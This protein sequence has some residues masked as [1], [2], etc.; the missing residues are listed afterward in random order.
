MDNFLADWL[1]QR[2]TTVTRSAED[3]ELVSV[4]TSMED[5]RSAGPASERVY[6]FANDLEPYFRSTSTRLVGSVI[7]KADEP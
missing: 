3:A 4:C 7:R 6:E 1:Q 5:I 2:W